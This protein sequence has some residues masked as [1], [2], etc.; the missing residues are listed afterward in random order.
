MLFA[1]LAVVF[2][3]YHWRARDD[4][5]SWRRFVSKAKARQAQLEQIVRPHSY[6]KPL[7]LVHSLE[8]SSSSI[9]KGSLSRSFFAA[10]CLSNHYV[11]DLEKRLKRM[12]P[13]VSA[14]T[15]TQRTCSRTRKRLRE[16][17]AK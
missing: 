2:A 15:R 8:S 11:V 12:T 3:L 9:D 1:L 5:E 7:T 6:V 16:G 14:H 17:R 13:T 4:G 10:V